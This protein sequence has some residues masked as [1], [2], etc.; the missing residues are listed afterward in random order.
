M[1]KWLDKLMDNRNFMKLVA[2]VMAL[3]FFSSIYDSNNQS[4]D[5]NI[6]GEQDTETIED[7]PVKSYYD[8][9]NLVVSGVPQ[10]VKLT[11]KGP[12]PT[13]Q[14]A[15]AQKDFEVYADLSEAKVGTQRVK[16]KIKNLSDKLTAKINPEYV[17]VTVQEKVTKEF[18]VKVEFNEDMVAEGYEAGTPVVKPGK[19]KITG[20]K[21]D[22]EK[23]RYVK[24]VVETDKKLNATF[25]KSAPLVALD[26]NYKKLNVTFEHVTVRVTIPIKLA[27]K[28]VPIEIEEKGTPPEGVHIDSITLDT[29]EAKISGSEEVLNATENVRVEVD[30]SGINGNA[31]MTLPVII[32]EGIQEVEPKTVKATVK[33]TLDSEE[34]I[35]T[36]VTTTK[37]LANLPINITGISEGMSAVFQD[38]AG[39]KTS[40]TITGTNEEIEKLTESDY[41]LSVNAANL[42]EGEHEVRIQVSGPTTNSSFALARETARVLVKAKQGNNGQTS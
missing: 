12:K 25:D 34:A 26:E 39:G 8:T 29:K 10:T 37:T 7:I 30:V 36:N 5:I 2:L 35:T 22:I 28:K 38:P 9:D 3:L 18:N 31:E 32:P 42:T 14:N 21:D 41:H 19:V 16:L 27:N 11:L 20:G 40:L 4:N 33:V 23:I 15:K 13:L 6:P 17:N 1:D 24:A